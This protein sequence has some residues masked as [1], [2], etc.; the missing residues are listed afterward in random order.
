ML[1]FS[2]GV[3]D[4]INNIFWCLLLCNTKVNIV[5]FIRLKK[6]SNATVSMSWYLFT[7]GQHLSGHQQLPRFKYPKRSQTQWRMDPP[8]KQRL[9]ITYVGQILFYQPELGNLICPRIFTLDM[10]HYWVFFWWKRKRVVLEPRH[11]LFLYGTHCI[12]IRWKVFKTR[13]IF[14]GHAVKKDANS[15]RLL[16]RSQET[17]TYC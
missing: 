3:V 14:D 15:V 12:L 9:S 6:V 11:A 8:L 10:N 7:R 4:W 2:L 16:W 13:N 17:S 5:D 1:V